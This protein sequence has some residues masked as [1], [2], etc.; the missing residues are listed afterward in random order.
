VCIRLLIY[1]LMENTY[2][3][4]SPKDAVTSAGGGGELSLLG[5]LGCRGCVRERFRVLPLSSLGV[6][7]LKGKVYECPNCFGE[8]RCAPMPKKGAVR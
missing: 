5:N 4:A 1:F 7:W 8:S 6:L 2:A 3:R